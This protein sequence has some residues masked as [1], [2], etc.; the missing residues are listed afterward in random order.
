M[1]RRLLSLLLPAVALCG[2]AAP[3]RA[4]QPVSSHAMVHTCCTPAAM[5]ERIFSEAAA[6]G[7]EFI[8]VDVELSGIYESGPEAPDWR[9]LDE[10]V[11]LADR[12]GLEVLGVIL[13]TPGW[14][15]S[16]PERGSDAALC[17]PRDPAEFGRLAAEVAHHARDSIRYWEILNEPDADWAFKGTAGDYARMLSAAYDDI[18]ARVPEARVVQGGVER[19]REHEWTERMLSTPGADAARKFDIAALHLRLRLRNVLADLPA[20]LRAY[21]ELLAARGFRG[22]VWVTEHGYPA[23]PDFQR[24]PAYRGGDAAQAAFLRDSIPRLTAAGADQVFVTLRDNLWGEYLSEGLVHIDEA[25]PSYP[26][27]RRPAF[28]TVLDQ[29]GELDLEMLVELLQSWWL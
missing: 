19:P 23:D 20:Q 16:C 7:A 28:E 18:H 24:D 1:V 8:R 2:A 14:L 27:V 10:V 11:E 25:K 22:P 26:A 12:H 9:A 4:D 15:S 17:P 21:R 29:S 3:A 13:A 5:K 6:S